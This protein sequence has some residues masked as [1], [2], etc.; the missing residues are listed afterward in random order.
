M[1]KTFNHVIKVLIATDVV[2]MSG[3]GFV[4]PVFAVFIT[5]RIAGG[6][7]EVIGYSAAI[8]W[9]VKSLVVI[10]FGLFLDRNHGEKDD[11]LFIL[12]GSLLASI[13][14]FSYIFASL[15]WHIYLLQGIYAIGMGMNIPGYTAIFTR[16]IDKGREAFDWSTRSSFVGF[17]TGIAGALGGIVADKWGF[18]A[19]FIIVGIIIFISALLPL[20][21]LGEISSKDKKMPKVPQ[22][23]DIQPPA[24]K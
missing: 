19:L 14:I 17:S 21:C 2:L 6:N 3:L 15:P 23:K 9:I 18:N 11:L 20:F 4:V 16:H 1:K 10:P 5:D 22:I 24:P 8:Y 13:A 7:L 12:I